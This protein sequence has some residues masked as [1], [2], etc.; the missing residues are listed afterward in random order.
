MVRAKLP[1]VAVISAKL[2]VSVPEES[3]AAGASRGRD[4]DGAQAAL[5]P[6]KD[7]QRHL[8]GDLAQVCSKGEKN[9]PVS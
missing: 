2:P 6:E 8:Q 9:E 3:A 1:V 7:R 4:Q 5:Q